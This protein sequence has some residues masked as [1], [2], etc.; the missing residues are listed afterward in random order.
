MQFY[1]VVETQCQ[2]FKYPQS[3]K[4]CFFCSMSIRTVWR[5][6]GLQSIPFYAVLSLWFVCCKINK[7]NQMEY[8]LS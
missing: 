7:K 3:N 2:D 4:S 6:S 1:R 5:T 8:C